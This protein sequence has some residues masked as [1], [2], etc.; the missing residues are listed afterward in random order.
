MGPIYVGLVRKEALVS[1]L[2]KVH[3]NEGDELCQHVLKV[4]PSLEISWLSLPFSFFCNIGSNNR[5]A[6]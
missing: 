5:D 2:N 4:N 1:N 6:A 3:S